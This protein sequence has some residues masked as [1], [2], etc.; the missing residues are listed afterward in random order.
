MSD[1]C[2][3]LVTM[4]HIASQAE[5]MDRMLGRVGVDPNHA[6]RVEDGMDWYEARTR[7][8]DCQ[9]IAICKAWL[10]GEP[11]NGNPEPPEFCPNASFFRDCHTDGN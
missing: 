8:L 11:S 3:G 5:M 9:S 1:Y 6:T 4:E 2:Y 7:C 10:A